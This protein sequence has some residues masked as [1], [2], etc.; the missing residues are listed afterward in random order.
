MLATAASKRD[1]P[2]IAKTWDPPKDSLPQALHFKNMV[3]E[4]TADFAMP[5]QMPKIGGS[6][7]GAKRLRGEL[8]AVLR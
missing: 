3:G 8:L 2:V 7:C 5:I 4:L 1:F 6:L